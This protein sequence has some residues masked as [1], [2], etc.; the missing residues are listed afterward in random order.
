MRTKPPQID[1]RPCGY[2]KDPCK[3]HR[4]TATKCAKSNINK[5]SFLSKNRE[6]G[7]RPRGGGPGNGL[8]KA[9]ER[10]L[11]QLDGGGAAASD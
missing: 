5:F 3:L 10:L 8:A 6:A 1:W 7:R 4:L 2:S 9:L 11:R